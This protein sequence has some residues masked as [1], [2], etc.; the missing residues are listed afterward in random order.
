MQ[1]VLSCSFF[2]TGSHLDPALEEAM[3]RLQGGSP[4]SLLDTSARLFFHKAP[5]FQR[6][7]VVKCNLLSNPFRP[8]LKP[9]ALFYLF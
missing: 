4:Q 3:E 1:D 2:S 8:H 5:A 7:I 9:S 6:L